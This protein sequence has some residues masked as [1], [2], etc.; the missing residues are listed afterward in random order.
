MKRLHHIDALRAL[1]ALAVAFF[2]FVHG[3]R[4]VPEGSWL[5]S[6]SA[7]GWLGVEV[8]FVISG[9]I[10][11]YTMARGGY[12]L[13]GA[14]TFVKKRVVRLDPPYLVA[15][16]LALLLWWVSGFVPGFGGEPFRWEP[17]RLALHLGYLNAFTDL[18]W[19]NP[20]FWT[21]A[22][23]FQFY[24]AL[25]VGFPLLLHR[26][27]LVRLAVL[28][29]MCGLAFV[30]PDSRF[31]LHYLGLFALGAASAH[32]LLGLL[33]RG[34]YLVLTA[35]LA[36]ATGLALGP[37]VAGVGVVTAL[38]IVFVRIPEWKPVAWLGAV[39]Y[40][41]YLLH[42]P[43]GGRVVNL[44]AR[45]TG[46]SAPLQAAAILAALGASLVAAHLLYRTVELPSQRLSSS[47]RYAGKERPVNE[48]PAT[49][50]RVTPADG[51][52]LSVP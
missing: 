12:R 2:H 23:E 35:A 41:L 37:V 10:L 48:R 7:H 42:I 28:A 31:V 29:A 36:V 51:V 40:S 4:V 38:V 52:G 44:A 47:I 15:I 34:G 20:A 8:F 1:A 17:L 24:L 11:P 18:P 5:Y 3:G 21:L 33:T 50:A 43:I 26:S 27:G 49:P 9:F 14:W 46:E 13:S 16:A 30:Q 19:Y 39:S 6:A 45:F 32:Y 25:A 22:I